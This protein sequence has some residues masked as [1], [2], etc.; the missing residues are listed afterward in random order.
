[1]K[2]SKSHG[3]KINPVFDHNSIHL[4]ISSSYSQYERT[5]IS[6]IFVSSLVVR[7]R[8]SL[9]SSWK[10]IN[11]RRMVVGYLKVLLI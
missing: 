9:I 8:F 6:S 3:L 11:Y 4:P 5:N 10:R 1:M 2:L 7:S